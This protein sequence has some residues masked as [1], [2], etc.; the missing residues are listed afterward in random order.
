[1]ECQELCHSVDDLP[2]NLRRF[3]VCR[4]TSAVG[5]FTRQS[6]SAFQHN[7][8]RNSTMSV[9]A[10]RYQR[11]SNIRGDAS[12]EENARRITYDVCANCDSTLGNDGCN[13]FSDDATTNSTY[14]CDVTTF[15]GWNSLTDVRPH[16]VKAK[17]NCKS[18][19]TVKLRRQSNRRRRAALGKPA[20]ATGSSE[21]DDDGSCRLYAPQN[22]VSIPSA[23]VC[24]EAKRISCSQLYRMSRAGSALTQH[25][26]TWTTGND[27]CDSATSS[28]DAGCSTNNILYS[29]EMCDAILQGDHHDNQAERNIVSVQPDEDDVDNTKIIPSSEIM[30]SSKDVNPD[31]ETVEVSVSQTTDEIVPKELA[32]DGRQEIKPGYAAP[33]ERTDSVDLPA[34]QQSEDNVD[35]PVVSSYQSLSQKIDTLIGNQETCDENSNRRPTRPYENYIDD[36]ASSPSTSFSLP[37]TGTLSGDF[38]EVLSSRLLN[39]I[40]SNQHQIQSNRPGVDRACEEQTAFDKKRTTTGIAAGPDV[41]NPAATS[42]YSVGAQRNT[43]VGPF[44]CSDYDKLLL[45][46]AYRG[47]GRTLGVQGYL[48]RSEAAA[49]DCSEWPR[50]PE[51]AEVLPEKQGLPERPTTDINAATG[52]EV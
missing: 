51:T 42:S 16:K 46:S 3:N 25:G 32:V 8:Q 23:D 11:I 14:S 38:L 26:A 15:P 10:N 35:R 37:A 50:H 12:A 43:Q 44:D 22:V 24:R 45:A 2:A 5:V 41:A 20:R 7:E 21:T 28:T 31:D 17:V 1:M 33:S 13:E 9:S 48:Q 34:A 18:S 30:P 40:T 27:V 6:A 36:T 29:T 4:N 47:D 49:M 39:A 52:H 19:Y